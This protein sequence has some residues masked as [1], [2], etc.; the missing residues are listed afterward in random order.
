MTSYFMPCIY[1][2][3]RYIHHS[4]IMMIIDVIICHA[5]LDE[6]QQRFACPWSHHHW[7]STHGCAAC[8]LFSEDS[9]DHSI[10]NTGSEVLRLRAQ[11][12][13]VMRQLDVLKAATPTNPFAAS[14]LTTA[15]EPDL[16]QVTKLDLTQR[17]SIHL[18]LFEF[19]TACRRTLTPPGEWLKHFLKGTCIDGSSK[20]PLDRTIDE[21]IDSQLLRP[22]SFRM[23]T[24]NS[25][26]S[27][28]LGVTSRLRT[29][30]SVALWKPTTKR[31]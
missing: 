2:T 7:W 27:L 13:D 14:V 16:D 4:C 1:S 30:W 23:M 26:S 9:S 11:L 19:E 25:G 20:L 15:I 5:Y 21:L 3:I 10:H 22:T 18:C 6:S 31:R 17:E 12:D 8:E 24:S 29:F 28:D